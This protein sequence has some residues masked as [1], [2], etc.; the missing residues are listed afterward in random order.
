MT[1][2]VYMKL[3]IMGTITFNAQENYVLEDERVLLRLIRKEDVVLLYQFIN[4]HAI[5][6]YNPTLVESEEQL[7][8][9]FDTTIQNNLCGKDYPFLVYDKRASAYAGTT[10]FYEVNPA[11]RSL[12][13]G[14]TWYGT[15]FQ[16]TGLNKHCKFLLLKFAFED[17]AME[18]VEL[19]ADLRNERSI[20]AMKSIGCTV[21][22]VL[23]K[24]IPLP[25]GT[26][27]DTIIL[28]I[29]RYEWFNEVKA[30]LMNKL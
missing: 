7:E 17:L 25:D 18:R 19:R 30:R 4:D 28:S 20:R 23:R 14:Y 8:Q 9:Y 13:L 10:R 2:Y 12:V 15:E 6:K 5:F 1:C 3:Q 16:G 27:R 21:E 24:N 29:L 26:R 11:Y 22:G